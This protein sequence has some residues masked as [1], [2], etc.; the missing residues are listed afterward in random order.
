[1]RSHASSKRTER[2]KVAGF[3]VR[4]PFPVPGISHVDPFLLIDEMGPVTWAPGAAIGAPEHPHRGFETVTYLLDGHMQ[5]EDSAGNQGDLRPGDVQ[6]MTAGRGVIHSELP[7][8]EFKRRGGRTHGFQIWINLP[9]RHKMMPPRY[10]DIPASSI[11]LATDEPNKATVRVVAGTCLGVEAVIDTVI[12]ITYLD[13]EL[14]PG[15]LVPAHLTGV[16]GPPA[17]VRGLVPDRREGRS[18]DGRTMCGPDGGLQH[19]TTK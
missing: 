19:P 1:M 9:S 16:N 14:G 7:H 8:P 15:V 3:P 2:W 4:R 18:C 10:Q 6:W 17:C 12:P 13:I 11:P 5:H